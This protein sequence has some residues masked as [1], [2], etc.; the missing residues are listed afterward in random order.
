MMHSRENTYLIS[1]PSRY[2]DLLRDGRSGVLAGKIFR[3]RSHRPRGLPI[4]L[5]SGYRVSF[6]EVRRPVRG[7]NHPLPSSVFEAC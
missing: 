1:Y 5:Y 2:S 6:P 3:T 7:T 4:L